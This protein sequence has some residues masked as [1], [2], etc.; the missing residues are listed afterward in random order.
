M[1]RTYG[2][3]PRQLI[4]SPH[5]MITL[6]KEFFIENKEQIIP[7]V[8][9]LKWGIYTGSPQMTEPRICN[10]Y[11]QFE[12][13]FHS[14]VSHC[15]TN[16]MYGIPKRCNVMQGIFT[17]VLLLIQYCVFSYHCEKYKT[18]F[19][20]SEPDTMNLIMWN[21]SDGIVRI[22]SFCDLSAKPQALLPNQHIDDISACGTDPQ[23]SQLWFG[24]KSGRV[25]VYESVRQLSSKYNKN[26]FYQHS[27]TFSKM[28][29]NSAFRSSS[30]KGNNIY[31][32]FMS[33]FLGS[34]IFLK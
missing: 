3:M 25:T 24:H 18:K 15:N 11:Q 30:S 21:E 26:R 13:I 20:G 23:S 6:T 17:I 10:F 12:V 8:Q 33:N 29:Y 5:P 34:D 16:V 19:V 28:S 7:N 4:K 27:T 22:K 32:E 14:L 1:V 9:G 2:Q 31:S